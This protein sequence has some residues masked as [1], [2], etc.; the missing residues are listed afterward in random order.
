LILLNNKDLDRELTKIRTTYLIDHGYLK[1]DKTKRDEVNKL[2]YPENPED[3]CNP[4]WKKLLTEIETNKEKIVTG[5]IEPM[6]CKEIPYPMYEYDGKHLIC[7]NYNLLDLS[8]ISLNHH[9]PYYYDTKGE[10]RTC[11]KLFF[12]LGV[13]EKKYRVEV[14][15]KGN[16]HSASPQ[17]QVH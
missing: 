7:L 14:R 13:F 11:A 3:P 6:F 1:H 17:F 2:F 10:L 8:Q 15:W 9:L 5:I 16:I 4:Y 12:Q